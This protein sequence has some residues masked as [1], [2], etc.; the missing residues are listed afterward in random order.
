MSNGDELPRRDGASGRVLGRY[1]LLFEQSR[2]IILFIGLDGRI[3]DANP[4][5]LAGYGYD[6]ATLT[7]LTVADLRDPATVADVRTQMRRADTE[8]L[9]FETRHQRSDGTPFPVEVSSLGVDL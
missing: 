4:A 6:Y 1:R 3:I 5:A 8:G 2:D 7:S 9:L